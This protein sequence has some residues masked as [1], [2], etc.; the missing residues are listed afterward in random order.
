MSILEMLQ[1]AETAEEIE[2]MMEEEWT[3]A[4]DGNNT[5]LPSNPK[6]DK[7]TMEEEWSNEETLEQTVELFTKSD[8]TG[9]DTK[10]N[11]KDTAIKHE[12]GCML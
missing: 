6:E 4:P 5:E 2:N 10:E 9:K 3:A 7:N 8:N 11:G 12:N 1:N